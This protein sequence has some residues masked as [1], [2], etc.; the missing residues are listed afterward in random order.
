MMPTG[1]TL[2]IVIAV[3]SFIAVW[4]GFISRKRGGQS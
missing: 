4:I 2:S 3:L 1:L